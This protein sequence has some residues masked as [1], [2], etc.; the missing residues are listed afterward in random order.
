MDER[1]FLSSIF[2]IGGDIMK[3]L[4]QIGEA[5]HRLKVHPSTLWR[6]EHKGL[7]RSHRDWK[8]WRFY[9]EDDIEKLKKKII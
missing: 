5:S 9:R 2:V 4:I 7:I 6:L 8:G 3:K 1:L